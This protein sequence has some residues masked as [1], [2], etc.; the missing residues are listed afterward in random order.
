MAGDPLL[1]RRSGRDIPTAVTLSPREVKGGPDPR[2][3]NWAGQLLLSMVPVGGGGG[4]TTTPRGT[5]FAG[6]LFAVLAP[7]LFAAFFLAAFFLAAVFFVA[8]FFVTALFVAFFMAFFR[9]AF[10]FAIRRA[11]LLCDVVAPTT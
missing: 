10:F 3:Q 8:T 4:G 2:T 5:L 11:P 9:V 1:A 6:C 7:L